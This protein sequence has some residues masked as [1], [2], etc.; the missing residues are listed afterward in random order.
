MNLI[1]IFGALSFFSFCYIIGVFI[2]PHMR[3]LN[4]LLF[5]AFCIVSS[6]VFWYILFKIKYKF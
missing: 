4:P 3:K 1:F 5:D 2:F 6:I